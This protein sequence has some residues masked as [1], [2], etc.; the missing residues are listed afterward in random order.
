MEILLRFIGP[1]IV[2]VLT[3]IFAVRMGGSTPESQEELDLL[4]L[5][6]RK[7]LAAL[8]NLIRELL[9]DQPEA[10]DDILRRGPSQATANELA[11]DRDSSGR[12]STQ[13]TT[14]FTDRFDGATPPTPVLGNTTGGVTALLRRLTSIT[15]ISPP[16]LHKAGAAAYGAQACTP[17]AALA[18]QRLSAARRLPSAR[19]MLGLL[20]DEG[21]DSPVFAGDGGERATATA[22]R[23][24]GRDD[25]RVTFAHMLLEAALEAELDTALRRVAEETS[26]L[27]PLGAEGCGNV[28]EKSAVQGDDKLHAP[29]RIR[30]ADVSPAASMNPAASPE[31]LAS[32][33]PPPS[34]LT[35][36]ADADN[37]SAEDDE[38]ECI[39]ELGGCGLGYR[40][41]AISSNGSINAD[42]ESGT[43]G[44][45]IDT[46]TN[47]T[48]TKGTRVLDQKPVISLNDCTA[49]GRDSGNSDGENGGADVDGDY[50]DDDDDKAAAAAIARDEAHCD[51]AV[52]RRRQGANRVEYDDDERA[53]AAAIARDEARQATTTIVTP[54]E[55]LPSLSAHAP[56]AIGIVIGERPPTAAEVATGAATAAPGS[57]AHGR[58]PVKG[59]KELRAAV[60]A[61]AH[62]PVRDAEA[63]EAAARGATEALSRAIATCDE[64][65]RLG[66]L[67][68]MISRACSCGTVA[69]GG[70]GGPT[71]WWRAWPTFAAVV[72]DVN[73]SATAAACRGSLA[74]TLAVARTAHDAAVRAAH[75]SAAAR[76]EA[77]ALW[78]LMRARVSRGI[79]VKWCVA[80]ALLA[81]HE[82]VHTA[83]LHRLTVTADEALTGGDAA[84]RSAC[85]EVRGSG[86]GSRRDLWSWSWQCQCLDSVDTRTPS[87]LWWW[88][89]PVVV[90]LLCC[91]DIFSALM[92]SSR[93][94]GC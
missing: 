84:L 27:A 61:G 92:S 74:C 40:Y 82:V 86:G 88:M 52:L 33:T 34:V 35:D 12:D 65:L 36:V 26:G 75:A 49:S 81:L 64:A 48:C 21:H 63:R 76:G 93:R 91:C 94:S 60:S 16:V 23:G 1:V 72:P 39:D 11:N 15:S 30:Y 38:S 20:V 53:A 37:E 14:R 19:R 29:E 79:C 47:G 85:V 66:L 58:A 9:T 10:L 18:V 5:R 13:A 32:E 7:T 2:I 70:V 55:Q 68:S 43:S 87:A 8:E 28:P 83:F 56:I 17:R 67:P 62:P 45:E 78:R 24:G 77:P 42:E 50:N 80:S 69:V 44:D 31:A 59:N 57:S 90:V 73:V 6:Q 51:V 41:A 22:S 3:A 89:V 25:R 46:H 4:R 71:A 54:S